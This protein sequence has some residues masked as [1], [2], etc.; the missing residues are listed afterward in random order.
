MWT[1]MRSTAYTFQKSYNDERLTCDI[2]NLPDEGI[3]GNDHM[4]FQDL[5][6]DVIADHIENWITSKIYNGKTNLASFLKFNF[7]TRYLRLLLL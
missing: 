7:I 4:M 5:N 6:N 1:S 2:F 3:Y